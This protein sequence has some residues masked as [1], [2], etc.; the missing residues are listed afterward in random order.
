MR[1]TFVVHTMTARSA[2]RAA[3]GHRQKMRCDDRLQPV[4]VRYV[5]VPDPLITA[6]AHDPLAVGVYVAIARLTM[7]AK[8]AVP[9]AARDLAIWMGSDRDADRVAIMRRIVKLEA[10]GWLMITR[11]IAAKH[12]LIPTWGR[13]QAGAV[14]PWCFEDSD[15]GRPQHLRGRRVPIG[16]LDDYLG[17]LE[18]QPD[19]GRALVC[20]YFTR[21]LLD[22]ADIGVYT[23]GLRAEI[24]PTPRLQHLNLCNEAGMLPLLDTQSLL[25]QAAAGVLTT[26]VDD[27]TVAIRLSVHGYARLGLRTPLGDQP[28]RIVTEQSDGSPHGSGAGSRDQAGM[29]SNI[30]DQ[31][32]SNC[33]ADV[34]ESLIAW[35]VGMIHESINH[36]SAANDMRPGGE[37]SHR[38]GTRQPAM[39]ALR[40]PGA[41]V[42]T[43][44]LI[45]PPLCN[46][47]P[48]ALDSAVV[49]GHRLLNPERTLRAGEWFELLALQTDHGAGQL[50]IWQARAGRSTVRRPFG[51]T[52]AY[53]YACAARATCAIDPSRVERRATAKTATHEPNDAQQIGPALDP[54]YRALLRTMGVREPRTLAATPPALIEAWSE[55]IEHPGLLARFDSPVG[56]AVRQMRQGQLPPTTAEL[57]HWAKRAARSAD[58]YETW[59]YIDAPLCQPDRVRQEQSLEQ[60]VRAL[61]PQGADTSELCALATW[62]EQGATDQEALA[63]LAARDHGGVA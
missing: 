37:I 7:A 62:I 44:H 46:V 15:C 53:Y 63:R 29:L 8:A 36:D 32:A 48:A 22:L 9:L 41:S 60:R 2:D 50:L 23:I 1:I 40:D 39:R 5:L 35:D 13:D 25:T 4:S 38:R 16:L 49:A 58:C 18:P 19:S 12:C 27:A 30:V 14:R 24:T 55:I 56:F 57:D 42:S 6:F 11:T 10:R 28:T 61:V 43:D 20:R 47:L 34:P 21:P 26:Y 31:D 45:E 51:V 17:R 54:K 59:R 3:A 33:I 52:P